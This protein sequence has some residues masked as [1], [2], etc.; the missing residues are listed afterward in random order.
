MSQ[1]K[2]NLQPPPN[3][4]FVTGYPG[5]PPGHDRPQAAV[6][7]AIEVRV[8]P[9]GVKA[10]WV[11]I[12]L[13][14]VE[15]L[16]GGGPASTFYDFVGPS[17]VNLWTTA[18]DYTLLRSQDFPFSI[19]IPESIPP[20]VT[21]DNRAAIG[22]E[23]V[24]SVCTKGKKG[25]L[26]KAKSVVSSSISP[27]II[28]K[29]ELHSTWP[30]YCQPESRLL[31]LE[32][33][34]LI[35]E[36]NH[37]CY[38]PGDRVSV[39]ATVKSDALHTEILRGFEFS[40]KE[41]TV[42]TP[43]THATG[44]KAAPMVRE[45][46]IAESKVAVNATLYGG[47]SQTTELSLMISPDHT[48]TTLNTARHIDVTYTLCVRALM[49]TGTPLVMELPVIISNWQRHVSY[50][51]INRIG[52]TP[53]LSL[54]ASTMSPI[55]PATNP[56]RTIQPAVST[57]TL[58]TT[59]PTVDTNLQH[60]RNNSATAY[61]T[62]PANLSS[63]PRADDPTSRLGGLLVDEFGTN[64][65]AI[66]TAPSL[67]ATATTSGSAAL[68]NAPS[69]TAT[70]S[71]TATG[72]N[73]PGSSGG[74]NRFTVKNATPQEEAIARQRTPQPTGSSSSGAASVAQKQWLSAEDEK[75][76]YEQARAQVA[77]VQASCYNTD[78]S[79]AQSVT[80][81]PARGAT[82]ATATASPSPNKPAWLSAQ[83]EKRLFQEAQAAVQRT[84]GFQAAPQATVQT[85]TRDT[86]DPKSSGSGSKPTSGAEL[87]AKA[88][89][90]RS[91][92]NSGL[93]TAGGSSAAPSLPKTVPQYLTAEQEKAALRRYEEAKRAVDRTQNLSDMGDSSPPPSGSAPIAYESLF[94]SSASR[95]TPV[96]SSSHPPPPPADA[97]PPFDS[98]VASGSDILSH[99]SEKERLRRQY[100]AQDAAAMARQNAPPPAAYP[101]SVPPPAPAPTPAPAAG[102]LPG[103]YASALEEKEAMRK[104]F[105]ARDAQVAA[106]RAPST[107]PQPPPRQNNVTPPVGSSRGND[108]SSSPGRSP[109]ANATGFRPTPVPPSPGPA[110]SRILTAAEE[111]A[112]LKAKFEAR[113]A[114][115][116]TPKPATPVANGAS[117]ASGAPPHTP[118][119]LMPRPPADYIKETQEEDARLSRLNGEMPVL[120][121]P[122]SSSSVNLASKG[123]SNALDMKPFTPFREGFGISMTTPTPGPPPPLPPKPAGE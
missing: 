19:R 89:A 95:G 106:A 113:D 16:P 103:Q 76:L 43:G 90:A 55:I 54:V 5:I 112:L 22:Y 87:Y 59:R 117:S 34:S 50:E 63:A 15:T 39:V 107:P 44:K 35:I 38:G 123:G 8:P 109:G 11:R 33:L 102:P 3:V 53:G 100:E 18:D 110:G 27:I 23:L 82:E 81:S 67:T 96:A 65:P 101:A 30:L 24:A 41:T 86:S 72:R 84:Q 88:I 31:A 111:K 71:S 66:T 104:K 91:V 114:G 49:A 108:G 64:R 29:H 118:P 42:F 119:P 97:P 25:F 6:K 20:S 85:H 70:T 121:G 74:G 58:P 62:M 26:R 99:L 80:S 9:Q 36:R 57:A 47:T 7:G 73:R 122:A 21:L 46:N 79:P 32:R 115:R 1:V 61:N 68:S 92:G 60:T 37:N 52:P 69:L 13:R 105:E 93:P 28:D 83:E 77:K 2:I 17:P 98:S 116:S 12:E 45:L 4:D 75:R 56:A 94:P 40:L 48:T 120:N 10:K 14:K 51:A 78:G